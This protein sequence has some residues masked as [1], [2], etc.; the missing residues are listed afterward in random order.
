MCAGASNRQHSRSTTIFQRSWSDI[1]IQKRLPSIVTLQQGEVRDALDGKLG[2]LLIPRSSSRLAR[3]YQDY[4]NET[5]T[6][7]STAYVLQGGIKAW[8]EKYAGEED[9]VDKD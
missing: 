3:R 8:L 5:G 7:T 1:A 4:L 9:L 6:T 2:V